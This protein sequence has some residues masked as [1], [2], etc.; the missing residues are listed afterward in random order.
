MSVVQVAPPEGQRPLVW[1]FFAFFLA[2]TILASCSRRVDSN[3]ASP[4]PALPGLELPRSGQ[5]KPAPR[6][7]KGTWYPVRFDSGYG[8][9]DED[10]AT[11]LE[12]H[13][14]GARFFAEGLAAARDGAKWGFIDPGGEWVIPA[15][16]DE[17]GDFSEGRARVQRDGLWGY[18]DRAGAEVLPL[19][20]DNAGDFHDGLANVCRERQWWFINEKG[21]AAAGGNS[22]T[23][24]RSFSEGLAA[25][26]EDGWEGDGGKFYGGVWGYIDVK[27]REVIAMIYSD[28]QDFHEGLAAVCGW[29]GRW[30]YIDQAGAER[31]PLTLP[32]GGEFSDNRAP[33][34]HDEGWGYI[35]SSGQWAIATDYPGATRFVHGRA[36]VSR[37]TE[38]MHQW[39]LIDVQGNPIGAAR[40][41]QPGEG[42]L[43]VTMRQRKT[44]EPE[45]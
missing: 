35:D 21:E 25:V 37:G 6:P 40:F 31:I 24:A 27:G 9:V 43:E 19:V 12:A 26:N 17:A 45:L 39:G 34:L 20:Y 36:L 16:Y 13:W 33:M 15:R 8:F 44:S 18:I 23:L 29:E 32:N 10:A 30:G 3:V 41:G 7:M 5:V 1:Q 2:L 14:E 42:F 11:M 38:A 28:A 22:Y 4:T